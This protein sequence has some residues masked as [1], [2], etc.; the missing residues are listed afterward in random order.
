[1]RIKRN[2]PKPFQKIGSYDTADRE[3]PVSAA[4]LPAF[5]IISLMPREARNAAEDAAQ[6]ILPRPG[7]GRNFSVCHAEGSEGVAGLRTRPI[8]IVG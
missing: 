2:I 3:G 4:S 7:C 1:M 6:Y 8:E 5:R